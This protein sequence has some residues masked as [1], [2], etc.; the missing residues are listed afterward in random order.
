MSTTLAEPVLPAFLPGEVLVHEIF[1]RHAV[2]E[3]VQAPPGGDV[4]D[5]HD[6]LPRLA[7]HPGP[8][9]P[10]FGVAQWGQ[11]TGSDG[12]ALARATSE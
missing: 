6:P 7:G 12:T 5:D 8:I 1:Q 4:A 10:T 11:L 3:V 9:G 2:N